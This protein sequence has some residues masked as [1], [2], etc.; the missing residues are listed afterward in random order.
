MIHMEHEWSSES[1]FRFF[2]MIF[3]A[4]KPGGIITLSVTDFGHSV[5]NFTNYQPSLHDSH[6]S[7]YFLEA[8]N[9]S[10]PKTSDEI[11]RLLTDAGFVDTSHYQNGLQWVAAMKPY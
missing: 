6:N 7:L 2:N 5:G 10:Y 4:L 3:E 11:D 8:S 9:Q 1:L